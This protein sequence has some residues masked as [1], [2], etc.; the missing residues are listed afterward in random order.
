[1]TVYSVEQNIYLRQ[2]DTGQVEFSGLPTDKVY[3]A[4]LSVYDEDNNKIIAELSTLVDSGVALFRLNS[5]FSDSL[6]VGDWVY[7]LK[8]CDSN[9][10]EDTILPETYIENG[11]LIKNSA[12]TFTVDY[13]YVEGE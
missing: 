1:M 6:K 11:V 7:G 10:T 9:G 3:T 4:Y 12:P 8:I 13:K 2:G 5:T